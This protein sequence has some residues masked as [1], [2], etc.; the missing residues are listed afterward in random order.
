MTLG[1]RDI[2]TDILADV[3]HICSA[4]IEDLLQLAEETG[5]SDLH[6][7]VPYP[8]SLRVNGV[9]VPIE[10]TSSLTPDDVTRIFESITTEAQRETF[11]QKLE[12]DF[13][14]QIAGLARARVNAC[15]QQ[16]SLS[17]S[18][19]IIPLRVP[20]IDELGLPQVCESLAMKHH[21][22]ILV[23]GPTGVGKTT[24]M[25]CMIN[26][27]NQHTARKIVTIEDPVEYVHNR[28]RAMIVQRDLGNDTRSF[29]DA[30]KH[31][32]R[33]DP[34]VILVGEM[35]DL[36]TMS[37]AL[38][39]AETGHLVISTLHTIG[40]ADTIER[41]IDAF[42]P[43]QQQQVRLQLSLVL[44]AVLSQILLPQA[45]GSGRVAAFEIMLGS[46]AIR[47]LIRE[48]KTHQINTVL[49]MG[50]NGG[51]RTLAHDLR[52]LARA[53]TISIDRA[54]AQ[55]YGLPEELIN[56]QPGS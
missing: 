6:L 19:R 35:R 13:M 9:I 21:G 16:G 45:D 55:A 1:S 23:T 40:A 30:L 25:A 36:E 28:D 11:Y 48:S 56:V 5:A 41:I 39:A 50:S 49:E 43:Y 53:G 10:D 42:P 26:Y 37:T 15:L 34:D 46:L 51:M 18:F 3:K 47:N 31:A 24:T 44:E 29:S 20:T 4:N 33:Q 54:L 52:R 17:I 12:L 32:L 8:P 27:M 2:T 22:L 7:T 38:T 14:Y